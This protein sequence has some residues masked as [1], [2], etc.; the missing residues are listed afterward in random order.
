[1]TTASIVL[2]KTK[3]ED[4]QTI[5]NCSLN[6]CIEKIFV[7]DNSPTDDLRRVISDYMPDKV[8]YI[9]GQGNIGYGSGHNIAIRK[10]IE[11]NARYHVVLN[12]D[13]EFETGLLD[14]LQ[15]FMDA[16]PNAGYVIPK[17]IH[18]DGE[19]GP[20]CHRI[21]TPFDIFAIRLLPER[22]GRR[23]VAKYFLEKYNSGESACNVPILSGCFMF[24]R[25]DT[26]KRAGLFD[27]RFFMYFEDFDL[28]RRIYRLAQNIYYPKVSIIHKHG[29]EHRSNKTML[30]ISIRSAIAY[31]NKWGWLFDKERRRVNEHIYDEENIIA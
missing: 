20:I 10:S 17:V 4:V 22:I 12:P 26:L 3:I 7:V 15:A 30:K 1:M 13:I 25:V 5:M 9:F 8:E 31:F 28:M 18:P 19:V 29:N 16:H 11:L 2:Y 21:P 6:S 23:Q 24:M 27:E 14:A